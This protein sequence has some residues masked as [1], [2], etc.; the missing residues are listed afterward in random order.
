MATITSSTNIDVNTI[1]SQL[2]AIERTPIDKLKTTATG[3]NSKISAYGRIQS[4]VS[5]IGDAATA[6]KRSTLWQGTTATS[7]DPTSVTATATG[8]AAS[9]SY[10][11]AVSRLAQAHSLASGAMA[12]DVPLG[13]GTL[14]LQLG[15]WLGGSFTA[16]ADTAAVPVT[17]DA[18]DTLKDVKD[19][20]NAANAGVT[21]AIVRDANG[22]RL[23]LTS[24]TTGETNGLQITTSGA[25]LEA[26]AY[27]PPGSTGTGLGQTQPAANALATI[28]GLS[29]ESEKN[30]LNDVLDGLSITLNKVTTSPVAV[31]VAPDTASIKKAMEG[32]VT[33]YNALNT[34]IVQQTKYDESTKTAATLQGDSTA[35]GM[36]NQFRSML[37]ETSGASTMFTNLSS[38]GFNV[39]Q[40]GTLS[41]DNSKLEKGFAN[42]DELAKLF[43]NVDDVTPANQ[44][45]AERFR[46]LSNNLTGAEGVLNTRNDG[47]KALL[48][49][50]SDQQARLE[51][52]V[53]RVEERLLKQY[54]ALDVAMGQFKSTADYVSQQM[55]QLLNNSK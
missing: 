31:S 46:L 40:D 4:M 39:A 49:R 38:V 34:Y 20:I 19:K 1:V 45:M 25:G 11:V 18:D 55:T 36:R 29:V 47:L 30:T 42:L 9:G 32:F 17:I 7:A 21:A 51:D 8:T 10:S 15:K 27:N 48:K 26:L 41:I 50:N 12:D 44:G 24:K 35:V 6:L 37:R 43:S 13:A 54:T 16:K 14:T 23:T 2:V 53:T 28:N 3:I 52:R 22:A 33:A 5:A